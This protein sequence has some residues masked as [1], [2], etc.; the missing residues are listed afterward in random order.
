[1]F[2]FRLPRLRPEQEFD[3]VLSREGIFLL[4]NLL[5]VGI[6]F[7]TLWGTIF[8]LISVAI[9]HQTMTVGPPFYTSVNGPTF[10]ALFLAMGVGPLFAWRRT[11][12]RLLW[13]TLCMC[14]VTSVGC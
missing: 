12:T 2:I 11:Y 6:A 3:S 9:G 8:P 1:L 4:N 5:L 13:R 7:A 14:D 10:A